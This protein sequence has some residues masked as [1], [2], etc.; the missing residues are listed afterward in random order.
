MILSLQNIRK[1]FGPEPVLDGVSFDIRSN[2]RVALVGPNGTGKTTLLKIIAGQV[3]ADA[4][5]VDIRSGVSIGYLEQQPD[6][7]SGK[8]V[9]EMARQALQ[10]LITMLHQAEQLAEQIADADNEADRQRLGRRFDHLQQELHRREGYHLDHKIERILEGL[11]FDH[12]SFNQDVTSLSGG[13]QNRLLLARLLLEEPEL[14]LLDE[15]S[16]HLDLQATRWLEQFLSQTA[17]AILLISHD[18]YFLD[19][20]TA[21]T[22]ELYHG[23]V[24]AYSGNYTAYVTQKE[25]RLAV[26]RRTYEK[27]QTEIA[28]M[29]EFV[30]RH[31][32]GQKHAQAE[33]R[34]KKLERIEPVPPPRAINVPAMHFPPAGRSGDIVLR[35]EH[36]SKSYAQPL[37]ADLTFDV[38]RGQKWAILGPNGC[39]KTTLLRCLLR[40]ESADEG[41][42]V[43]GTGVVIGYFDQHLNCLASDVPVVDA[44]RPDHKEFVESQRRDLLARFG[45]TGDMVF[46]KVGSLSGGERN[47]AALAYLSTCD[48]N[49]LVLDEPTNHLDLWAREALEGALREF[50]GTVLLVSH[51][52]YFLNQVADHLV[53]MD[54][55]QSQVI[56]G[57][58]ETYQNLAASGLTRTDPD[59]LQRATRKPTHNGPS[60]TSTQRPAATRRKRKFP[61]RKVAELET[62]IHECE[63]RA[64]DLHA[65][66]ASPDVLRDGRRV[67]KTVAELDECKRQLEHLYEHWEEATELN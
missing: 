34:R 4:G 32:Y 27:Q 23:T 29:E 13:Q 30:R 67:K 56:E 8:S 55:S 42:V 43:R 66:L 26:Q 64:E 2:Q 48:A 15:P 60:T 63:R 65:Q 46:Q 35:V 11:G 44:I 40:Q 37:F 31:H 3:E 62:D 24:E 59:S 41:R 12:E 25:E 22:L 54:G 16:N 18:R 10:P 45:I 14:L 57:N 51:D 6:F 17:S 53:V 7:P 1:H 9:R 61:Y 52:R 5:R 20:V 19:K 50:Q 49:L 39:G 47:R 28:K 33:D 36:L 58:F 38:L 21:R